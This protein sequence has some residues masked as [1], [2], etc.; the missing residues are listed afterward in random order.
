M[1]D[2][3]IRHLN[4][5]NALAPVYDLRARVLRP[6]QAPEKS[7]YADDEHPDTIH[8]AAFSNKQCVGV[9][10][11]LRENGVRLRGMAVEP[12]LQNKGVGAAILRHAQQI[13]QAANEDL[14]CNARASAVGFYQKLGWVI[15]GNAFDIPTVG[16]HYVMRW[17]RPPTT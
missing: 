2:L 3:E 13:A 4:Q 8:L 15:E 1:N 14:W 7:R 9:A 16:Q 10:T 6:G 12:S 11:L 17:R 5:I